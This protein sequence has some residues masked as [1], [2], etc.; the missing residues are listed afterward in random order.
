VAAFTIKHAK[1]ADFEE[2]Y[3]FVFD[4]PDKHI[5]K[6]TPEEVEKLVDKGAFY[7][8][9]DDESGRIVGCCYVSGSENDPNPKFEFGGAFVDNAY[10]KHGVF[11]CVGLAAI[12]SHFANLPDI[13]L[14]AHVVSENAGPVSQLQKLYFKQVEWKQPYPKDSIPGIEHME[15]DAGGNVYADLY[16]FRMDQRLSIVKDALTLDGMVSGKDG[17]ESRVTFQLAN[18]SRDT[19]E[20]LAELF[21][22]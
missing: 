7:V 18:F 16:E 19:L 6:R 15:A 10:R 4:K 11:W 17:T 3:K 14:I 13:P 22:E 8:A 12:L 21:G 20:E 1:A 9:I 5:L 2:L